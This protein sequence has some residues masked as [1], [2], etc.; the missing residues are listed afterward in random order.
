MQFSLSL[1]HT[2]SLSFLSFHLALFGATYVQFVLV[3]SSFSI[4]FFFV[5]FLRWGVWIKRILMILPTL[6]Q[7]WTILQYTGR[8]FSSVESSRR[9]VQFNLSSIYRPELLRR[10][11]FY[12]IV[13]PVNYRQAGASQA[14][15]S[16]TRKVQ[17]KEF[18]ILGFYVDKRQKN[19]DR[20]RE[21]E[22]ERFI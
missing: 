4:W 13:Q 8:S 17:F 6:N 10:R 2:L 12:K 21:I 22:T 19:K 9:E 15:D 20:D 16:S 1:P 7:S 3:S 11:E 18:Y 5:W 14:I